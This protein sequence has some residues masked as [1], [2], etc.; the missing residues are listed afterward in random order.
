MDYSAGKNG[1][2]ALPTVYTVRVQ[3]EFGQKVMIG[4]RIDAGQYGKGKN[5]AG[6]WGMNEVI[7]HKPLGYLYFECRK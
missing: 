4:K 5:E 2:K 3:H 7:E 1:V 6:Y